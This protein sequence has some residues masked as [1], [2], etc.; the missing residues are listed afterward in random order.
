MG[1]NFSDYHIKLS[2]KGVQ[3]QFTVAPFWKH[4]EHSKESFYEVDALVHCVKILTI[5]WHKAP[6]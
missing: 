2:Y 1:F 6:D 5:F 3:G 4:S